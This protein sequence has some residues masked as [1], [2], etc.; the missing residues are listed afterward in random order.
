MNII[1]NKAKKVEI[2]SQ[3][4]LKNI[5]SGKYDKD[6]YLDDATNIIDII[7]SIHNKSIAAQMIEEYYLKTEINDYFSDFETLSFTIA[8]EYYSKISKI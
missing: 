7:D 6:D 4:L 1:T 8:E 5:F 2:L 3:I